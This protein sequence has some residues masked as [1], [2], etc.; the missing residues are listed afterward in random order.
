MGTARSPVF[1]KKSEKMSMNQLQQQRQKISIPST[2]A[3]SPS[4]PPTTIISDPPKPSAQAATNL[5]DI[6]VTLD[7][8]RPGV[9]IPAQE[10]QD[11]L[12]LILNISQDK[13]TDH[14]SA[15]VATITNK[16]KSP[17]S[18]LDLKVAVP[19]TCRVRIL[20]PVPDIKDLAAAS[21]FLPPPARSQIILISNPDQKHP[22]FFKFVL[23]YVM[24]EDDQTDMGEV[25][26][27][28][29]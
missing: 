3:P 9:S 23:S 19:K 20:N 21:P 7:Q 27:L 17:V 11:G 5:T 16:S 10:D 6:H 24:N 8:I 28:P 2:T 25:K 29:I 13:I 4:A 26:E 22:V 15:I 14:V 12:N 18:N 1:E